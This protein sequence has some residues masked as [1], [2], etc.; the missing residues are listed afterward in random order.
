MQLVGPGARGLELGDQPGDLAERDAG[1]DGEP[2]DPLDGEG[3]VTDGA[4]LGGVDRGFERELARP[5]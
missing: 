3:R 1:P 4:G 5:F 2:A